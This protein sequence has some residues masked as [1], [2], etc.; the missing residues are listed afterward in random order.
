MENVCEHQS[1]FV[2]LQKKDGTGLVGLSIDKIDSIEEVKGANTSL[3]STI[4]TLDNS[5]SYTVVE[6]FK[7]IMS[8][9]KMSHVAHLEEHPETVV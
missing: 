7:L 4:V 9:I 8:T 5:K 3:D 1:S 6:S 2:V